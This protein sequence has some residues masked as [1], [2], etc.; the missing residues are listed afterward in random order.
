M[1]DDAIVKP[2]EQT[3]LGSLEER[4]RLVAEHAAALER[5]ELGV[6]ERGAELALPRAAA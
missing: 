5:L 3:W 2:I 1:P 4:A 6:R